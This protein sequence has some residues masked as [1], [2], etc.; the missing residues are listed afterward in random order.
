MRNIN[1]LKIIFIGLLQLSVSLFAATVEEILITDDETGRKLEYAN[2]N[3]LDNSQ[4]ILIDMQNILSKYP[5]NAQAHQIRGKVYYRSIGDIEKS[6]SELTTAQNLLRQIPYNGDSLSYELKQKYSIIKGEIELILPEIDYYFADLRMK[7]Q[8]LTIPRLCR[9]E[10]A[11]IEFQYHRKIYEEA[12]GEQQLRLKFLEKKL[13][14]ATFQFSEWDSVAGEMYFAIRYFPVVVTNVDLPYAI[15]INNEYRYHF[16]L[17]GPDEPPVEIKWS[18]QYR[19][20]NSLPD[21]TI[22]FTHSKDVH[23]TPVYPKGA[24]VTRP[25]FTLRESDQLINSYIPVL[26]NVNVG[27][28][29]AEGY[30]GQKAEKIIFSLNKILTGAIIVSI[31]FLVR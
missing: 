19:L 31:F 22:E 8:G 30:P 28:R 21:M 18:N 3:Y 16:D 23:I 27:I 24:I 12:T 17:L 6:V 2:N 9:I 7:I 14:N 1:H 4:T 20:V 25:Y 13:K 5:N 26:E 11:N 10:N 15:T 29:L